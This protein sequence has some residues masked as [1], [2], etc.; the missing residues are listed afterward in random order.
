MLADATKQKGKKRLQPHDESDA[1]STKKQK[2]KSPSREQKKPSQKKKQ[3]DDKDNPEDKIPLTSIWLE[4]GP[5]GRPE[6]Y[7]SME[8]FW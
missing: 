3:T 1:P 5:G 7:D 2:Q 4:E 6:I 8:F